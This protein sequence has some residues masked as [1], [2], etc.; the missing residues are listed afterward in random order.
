M[1]K[2]ITSS[3]AFAN[4]TAPV[5]LTGAQWAAGAMGGQFWDDDVAATDTL[6]F[7]TYAGDMNFDG[8]VD[9]SDVAL[10][11]AAW[12]RR[13][14]P[15]VKGW[16][17]GDFNYDG[18][19]TQADYDLFYGGLGALRKLGSALPRSRTLVAGAVTGRRGWHFIAIPETKLA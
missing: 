12:A 3:L 17:D 16:A 14:T 6:V 11:N 2:G 7:Y 13:N 9:A 8:M 5:V 18:S 10:F 15:G 4:H 1:N 19:V